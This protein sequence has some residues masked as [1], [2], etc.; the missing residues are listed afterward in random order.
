MKYGPHIFPVFLIP[1]LIGIGVAFRPKVA[2]HR[3]A[4]IETT[5]SGL[6]VGSRNC[7]GEGEGD[8]ESADHGVLHSETLLGYETKVFRANPMNLP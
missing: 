5:S 7:S 1:A 6:G 3:V 4:G 8:D 2:E